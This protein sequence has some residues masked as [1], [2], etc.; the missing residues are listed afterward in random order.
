MLIGSYIYLG[1]PCQILDFKRY[2]YVEYRHS[3]RI[4]G[5]SVRLVIASESCYVEV[6]SQLNS[7][8][9]VGINTAIFLVYQEE[10]L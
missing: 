2:T 7:I 10:S 5:A 4:R 8:S 9:K 1:N 6:V 3:P